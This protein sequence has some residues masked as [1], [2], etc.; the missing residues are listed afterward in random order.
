MK[1]NC[2]NLKKVRKIQ[3]KK[4]KMKRITPK[5]VRKKGNKKVKV[6]L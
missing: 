5:K 2:S 3:T 4:E 6:R 1:N